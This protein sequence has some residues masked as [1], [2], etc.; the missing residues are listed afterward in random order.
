MAELQA[1]S[2]TI[3]SSSGVES[4]FILSQ[5]GKF[6]IGRSDTCY[7]SINAELLSRRHLTLRYTD[8]QVFVTDNNSSNGSAIGDMTLVG[9]QTY[10]VQLPSTILLANGSIHVQLSS[11]AEQLD[12]NSP[13]NTLKPSTSSHSSPS[14]TSLLTEEGS[15]LASNSNAVMQGPIT[16]NGSDNDELHQLLLTHGQVLIGRSYDCNYVIDSLQ[17]SRKHALLTLSDNRITLKDLDTT[18]G[19]F[20]NGERIAGSVHITATDEIT[21]GTTTFAIQTGT[22]ALKYAIV[23]DNIE[24]VYAKGIVG[25]NTMSL[26][27]PSQQFIALM[28]P[29]GCGKSTLLKGLNGANPITSGAITVQGLKLNN[30]NYNTLKKYIG[31]VPQ[32]DIVHGE[33]S[34][35][36]TLFYAAKLR[37]SD[38]VTKQEIKDKISTV[39]ASLNLDTDA[40]RKSKVS[41]LSGGQRKR[42][43]IA[44]ELLN[45]PKI[46]FLDEPTSPLD[47]ETIEDFLSCIRR[48]VSKGQ[49]V[50]MVT[51]K[52]SDLDYVDQVIFLSKGGYQTYYGDKNQLLNHFGKDNIIEVYSMMK[53]PNQGKQWY[54]HWVRQNP[55]SELSVKQEVLAKKSNTALI[56]QYF[57]LC[58]RYFN[59]K[60]NDHA[61]LL[62]LL[63][64]PLIIGGLLVFIFSKLQVSVMFMMA[65]SAVWFGVSNAAKEIVSELPIYERERM[66]NLNIFNYI[67]SKL[68]VL[69]IIACIQVAIFIGITH[70]AYSGG[71]SV[72]GV[73]ADNGISGETQL[74]SITSTALFMLLLSVSATLFGLFLSAIFTTTEKVMTFVPIALMPQIMLAGII[75]PLDNN[76]KILLSYLTLGR[77][78]TEGFAHIQDEAARELGKWT[79]EKADI[80]ASVMQRVLR[81]PAAG[82]ENNAAEFTTQGAMQQLDLYDDKSGMVSLFPEDFTGVLI[83]ITLINILAFG[84]LLLAL[85]SKDKRFI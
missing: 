56:G 14:S 37:I 32:D 39:L 59:I 36:K 60:L 51:H 34:V 64:Q 15:D 50:I 23:A 2:V 13:P 83:A 53:N 79:N 25:L 78:G 67:A 66:Y 43:S 21:I 61:N 6:D 40:I 45:D 77:W 29:S 11:V 47:P 80:P 20:V 70:L 28:G 75:A 3:T 41:D 69:S 7:A 74:W 5:N 9:G 76:I 82:N 62:L 49:T 24:K 42:V 18:N 12:S 8:G 22:V 73:G 84:G 55:S 27:I 54:E 52:P 10:A 26:K 30:S 1:V 68:T 58:V 57:W 81:P 48:L 31:Y 38:D 35:E 46:L 71:S 4:E 44:V 65:V 17:A 85:R 16:H 72:S 63:A 33:L 19:T